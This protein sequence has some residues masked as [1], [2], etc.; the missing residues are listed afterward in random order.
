MTLADKDAL[1][2]TRS[3]PEKRNFFE[4]YYVMWND[5]AAG[6][7]GWVRYT[8]Y[9]S[10]TQPSECAVWGIFV[11]HAH[12]ERNVAIKQV[13]PYEKAV[14]RTDAFRLEIEGSGITSGAA[15][16]EVASGEQRMSWDLTTAQEGPAVLP[17]PPLLYNAPVPTTK[18]LAP[19]CWYE[20]QGTVV[21]NGQTVE[22]RNAKAQQAHFWGTKQ[23]EAWTW[24]NC[25]LFQEDPDFAFEGVVGYLKRGLPPLSVFTFRYEGKT[26]QCNSMLQAFVT[27]KTENTMDGWRFEATHGELR[28]KG[29]MRSTPEQMVLYRHH[30][31]DGLVRHSHNDLNATLTIEVQRKGA[32]GW[33]TAKTYHAD[34]SAK[35]EVAQPEQDPRVTM[36]VEPAQPGVAIAR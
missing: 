2:L 29:E 34:R 36:I 24:G 3:R 16:G 35:F 27:S 32:R 28:F 6:H 10:S 11:D 33:E 30:D 18:F 31:P 25:A 13:F 9:H 22:V 21:V 26:Y 15:W 4:T 19:S 23:V 12:P 7:A 1:N 14:Y 5:L 17:F 8:L 20:V